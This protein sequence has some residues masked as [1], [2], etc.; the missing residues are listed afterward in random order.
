MPQ[1]DPKHLTGLL[2]RMNRGDQEASGELVPLVY[3]ELRSIAE[4]VFASQEN[5]HT[6]QATAILHE[7]FL[8]MLGSAGQREDWSGRRHFFSVAALAMRR[9]LIDHA[10]RSRSAKRGGVRVTL[11][12]IDPSEETHYDVIELGDALEELG[13][14]DERVARVVELRFLGGLTVEEVAEELGV[15]VRTVFLDWRAGRAWLRERFNTP[16]EA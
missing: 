16:G 2:D 14:E 6:L 4:K 10:R 13:K 1:P 8:R 15:S 9:V 3:D 12:G 5:G 11:S 7:A